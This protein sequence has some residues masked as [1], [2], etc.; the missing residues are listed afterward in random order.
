MGFGEAAQ[1]Q[2]ADRRAPASR[3][4]FRDRLFGRLIRRKPFARASRASSEPGRTR[5]ARSSSGRASAGF[6]AMRQN[7]GEL[8]VGVEIVRIGGEFFPE[9]LGRAIGV[10]GEEQRLA[11]IGLQRR[12]IR[13]QGGGL[14]KLGHRSRVIAGGEEGGSQQELAFGR[15]AAA[16]DAVHA[17]SGPRSRGRCESAPCRGRSRARVGRAVTLPKA[18]G[19]RSRSG[20]R[21][22]AGGNRPAAARDS[23]PTGW[24]RWSASN[25]AAASGI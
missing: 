9:C 20:I 16:Q 15:I 21:R 25:S 6:P 11:V 19:C 2:R 3:A 18:S 4:E 23:G 5:T 22:F 24:A 8:E 10:A 1:I 13:I 14:R 17:Q 7:G 12:H